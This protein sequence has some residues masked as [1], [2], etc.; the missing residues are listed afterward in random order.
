MRAVL[1]LAALILAA[2]QSDT[3]IKADTMPAPLTNIAGDAVRGEA[4]FVT[5]DQGHCILCHHV[6][7]LSA[8]F[9]GNLGPSLDGVADRLS[10]AQLRL[11][12]VDYD[13]V[14]PGTTMPSYFRTQQLNQ[15]GQDYTGQ[16]VLSAQDIEDIIAY[17]MTLTAENGHEP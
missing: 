9:Q 1:M 15:V 10:P 13:A 3:P 14:A 12:I 11:R 7:N 16:T 6:S 8:E 4:L 17:L 2:C 5:R